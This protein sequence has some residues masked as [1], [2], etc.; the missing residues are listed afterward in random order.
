ME[1]VFK[2]LCE[3]FTMDQTNKR[4]DVFQ[5]RDLYFYTTHATKATNLHTVYQFKRLQRLAE[6]F[7]HNTDHEA[8]QATKFEKF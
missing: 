7:V 2:K 5:Y 3:S 4:K 1:K 8:K 6:T